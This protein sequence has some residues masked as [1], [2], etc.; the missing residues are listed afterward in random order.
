MFDFG[1][2]IVFDRFDDEQEA[3]EAEEADRSEP[4]PGDRQGNNGIR[5]HTLPSAVVGQP[6]RSRVDGESKAELEQQFR[7]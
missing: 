7:T 5:G 3:E 4:T 6:S 2:L 1:T